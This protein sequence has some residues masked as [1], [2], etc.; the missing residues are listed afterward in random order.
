VFERLHGRGEYAGTGIGLALCR[1]IAERHGG[2]ILAE[3]SPGQGAKFTVT[4]PVGQREE[5]L[6][7]PASQQ[8]TEISRSPMSLLD[9]KGKLVTILLADDD[10]DD[11][12]LTHDALKDSHLANE[13]RVVVDGQD[14]MDY[15]RREGRYANKS[16]DAPRPGII[17]LD[18]N[19][20]KK[21]GRE[22]LAEI[23]AD[24][25]LRRIPVVVLT[26]SKDEEDVFRT[27]DLGVSSFITKPV[28]FAGL[29]EAM[30]TWTRY[31]FELVEL[32]NGNGAGDHRG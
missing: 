28:T 30:R 6:A 21:D 25:S 13:V 5:V 17:L 15:L 12:E 8:T 24:E 4:L 14:L 22:A 1:K 9:H 32:P 20:P 27:Y 2:D 23:K 29:V 7:I 11:R 10:E 18:L 19:M 16:V 26:T 31:W 3:R